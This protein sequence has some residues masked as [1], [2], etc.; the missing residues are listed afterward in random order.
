MS[1]F[2]EI[3]RSDVEK[4]LFKSNSFLSKLKNYS[5]FRQGKV[6][7]IPNYVTNATIL[8]N[9]TQNNSFTATETTEINITWNLNNYSIAPFLVS[10]FD[11]LVTNYPKYQ[12]VTEHVIAQLAEYV[13]TDLLVKLASDV[14]ASRKV[15][16]SGDLGAGNS[17]SGT[18]AKKKISPS[19]FITLKKL[20]DKDN[21]PQNDRYAIVSAQL[22]SEL[23]S[24]TAIQKA[25]DFGQGAPLPEG[26]V[27]K[28]AGISII[29]RSDVVVTNA[30]GTTV[31]AV[32]VV[33]GATDAD[34]ILAFSS[35]MTGYGMGSINVYTDMGNVY[36]QG[37]LVSCR[38]E[39][40]AGNLRSSAQGGDGKGLYL[41][42]QAD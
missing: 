24:D 17:P 2:N 11:E 36:K 4:Q 20:M 21:I 35:S 6:I 23:L 26:V 16:T 40:V 34:A 38:T 18:D 13:E 19:D 15:F 27:A 12:V 5:E 32:G 14:S 29:S 33:P 42:V 7:H 41:I 25:M 9:P 31:N 30:T 8:K 37:N 22:Y 28:L 39:L 1:V 3:F 10:D